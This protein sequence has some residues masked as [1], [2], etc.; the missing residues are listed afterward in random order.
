MGLGPEAEGEGICDAGYRAWGKGEEGFGQARK[1]DLIGA[2]AH[3][4]EGLRKFEQSRDMAR[5]QS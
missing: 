1:T 5:G 2:G 3:L 4:E